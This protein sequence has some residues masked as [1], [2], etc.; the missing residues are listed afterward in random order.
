MSLAVAKT[1]WFQADFARQFRWYARYATDEVALRFKS[2]LD[3]TVHNISLQPRM[4]RLRR[5][6]NPQLAGLHSF[7]VEPPFDRFLAFYRL[8][9]DALE[10]VRLIHGSRNLSRRLLE[11]PHDS[12]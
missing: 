11:S 5:F 9:E 10:F 4:G 8:R 3:K 7:R 6:T 12:D 2:A 1:P